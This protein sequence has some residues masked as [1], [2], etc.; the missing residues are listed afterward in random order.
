MQLVYPARV[1][2]V[3]TLWLPDGSV[4]HIVRVPRSDLR[5][6]PTRITSIEEALSKISGVSVKIRIEY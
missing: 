1:T 5:Y 2:G 4:E 6:L 3:N